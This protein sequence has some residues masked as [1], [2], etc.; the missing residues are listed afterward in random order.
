MDKKTILMIIAIVILMILI[1][2]KHNNL[3]EKPPVVVRGVNEYVN[4]E[5][6]DR[7]MASIYFNQFIDMV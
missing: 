3:E 6:T 2:D 1:V 5:I 7:T 4:K